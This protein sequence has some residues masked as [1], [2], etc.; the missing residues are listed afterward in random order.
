MRPISNQRGRS[1]DV[2]ALLPWGCVAWCVVLREDFLFRR[3]AAGPREDLVPRPFLSG[4]VPA[5]GGG[6]SGGPDGG[7]SRLR[8]RVLL[9]LP[10]PTAPGKDLP[11]LRQDVEWLPVGGER[12]RLPSGR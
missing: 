3:G 10:G 4:R 9:R 5:A 7:L 1:G 6:A 2:A 8:V 11:G 12:V